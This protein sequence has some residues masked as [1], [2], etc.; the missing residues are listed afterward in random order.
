MAHDLK[1]PSRELGQPLKEA[2]EKWG[3]SNLVRAYQDAK[4]QMPS[5]P[6]PSP[7]RITSNGITRDDYGFDRHSRTDLIVAAARERR[8]QL[9]DLLDRARR[10]LLADVRQRLA[11]AELTAFGSYPGRPDRAVIPTDWWLPSMSPGFDGGSGDHLIFGRPSA[12]TIVHL[13][14]VYLT[15]DCRPATDDRSARPATSRGRRPAP[16]WLDAK[17]E[18]MRLLRDEGFPE[19]GDGGQAELERHI[20]D[21]LAVKDHHPTES[22]VRDHVSEWIAQYRR[23]PEA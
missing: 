16:Y 17:A 20:T 15:E 10:A 21:W 13:V 22:T 18:V 23:N 6:L 12:R 7:R 9:A 4:A 2:A 8:Q 11:N 3:E 19:P 5:D 14:R 1:E